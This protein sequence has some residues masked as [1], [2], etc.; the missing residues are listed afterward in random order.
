MGREAKLPK[1]EI[2]R[3]KEAHPEIRIS[4][5]HGVNASVLVCPL[6]FIP[7]QNV[8]LNGRLI[9]DKK[10]DKYALDNEPCELAQKGM[11]EGFLVAE[12]PSPQSRSGRYWICDP[13]AAARVFEKKP[14]VLDAGAV[15]AS[16]QEAFLLG[17][18]TR[19]VTEL[20]F[21][22]PE[23]EKTET[24][25]TLYT[26]QSEGGLDSLRKQEHYKHNS[27]SPRGKLD[28]YEVIVTEYYVL[29]H[30]EIPDNYKRTIRFETPPTERV[31]AADEFETRWVEGTSPSDA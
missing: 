22:D 16:E 25:R 12:G 5:R 1:A 2:Q 13:E 7:T 8:V 21:T 19:P 3:L 24:L 27:N 6:L 14:H 26:R 10:A 18:A 20:V 15:V 28:N 17:L 31:F 29:D 9:G 23:T 11:E 30:P 4:P